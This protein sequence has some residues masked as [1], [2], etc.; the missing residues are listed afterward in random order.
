MK[1]LVALAC[2]CAVL[3][4]G[5]HGA[6]IPMTQLQIRQIQTRHYEIKKPKRAVKAILNVLQDEGFIPKQANSEVGFVYAVKEMDIEDSRTRF[7]ATFWHGRKEATWSKHSVIECIANVTELSHGMRVR[8]SFQV[9]V[10]DN[11]GK[12]Q[13]VE[14]IH[15]PQFYQD[16]FSRVDKGV[17]LEKEGL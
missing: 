10:F 15:D 12:V 13:A 9:K 6:K 14:T 8:L 2:T 16:F 5:C 17:F 3:L 7:W 1:N 4:C 11:N